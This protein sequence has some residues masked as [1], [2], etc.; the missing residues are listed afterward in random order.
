MPDGTIIPKQLVT[1]VTQRLNEIPTAFIQVLVNLDDTIEEERIDI[2]NKDS[3]GSIPIH[4][5]MDS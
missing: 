5:T 2:S 3:N 1:R 4:N